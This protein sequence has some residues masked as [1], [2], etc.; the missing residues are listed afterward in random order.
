[1]CKITYW[2]HQNLFLIF[3]QLIILLGLSLFS[4]S[5]RIGNNLTCKRIYF[6]VTG[7]IHF[8][9]LYQ[10]FIE[11]IGL[12]SVGSLSRDLAGVRDL[13]FPLRVAGVC[14]CVRE[15]ETER[16]HMHAQ[17]GKEIIGPQVVLS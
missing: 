11:F 4:S 7:D 3:S 5:K 9:Y 8:H 1:M 6:P 15:R 12:S 14:V 2:S 10:Y 16:E 13:F 17:L